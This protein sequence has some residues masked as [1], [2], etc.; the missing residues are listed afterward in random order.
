MIEEGEGVE[1][2]IELPDGQFRGKKKFEKK[3]MMVY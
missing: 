1:F 3:K 2:A